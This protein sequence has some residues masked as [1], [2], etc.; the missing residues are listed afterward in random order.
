M[1]PH[2]HE[3]EKPIFLEGGLVPVGYKVL[4]KDFEFT[5]IYE[6]DGSVN[7][8]VEWGDDQGGDMSNHHSM[9]EAKRYLE[10]LLKASQ[11]EAKDVKV[12]L[13]KM[14]LESVVDGLKSIGLPDTP[15]NRLEVLNGMHKKV[16]VE[17]PIS[18]ADRPIV[19]AIEGEIV[20]LSDA[21]V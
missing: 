17:G 8:Y 15:H 9:F 12:D 21:G 3:T 4:T 20:R 10:V 19:Q 16:T 18:E 6:T 11:P 2:L 1:R 13:T 14:V 7:V 5:A